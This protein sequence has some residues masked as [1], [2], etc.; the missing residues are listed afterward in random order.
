MT[1]NAENVS[2]WWR[3]HGDG[4]GEHDGY[5]TDG[6]YVLL[7]GDSN[8]RA[9]L[10]DAPFMVDRQAISGTDIFD[11]D[12]LITESTVP[13]KQLSAIINHRHVCFDPVNK[14]P[15]NAMY[16]AC[17]ECVNGITEMYPN[18]DMVIS[19]ILIRAPRKNCTF[20]QLNTETLS[21]NNKLCE[22]ESDSI[23]IDNFCQFM[24]N[25]VTQEL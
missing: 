5:G 13:A 8:C 22:L 12:N 4:G 3:H 16:L 14:N 24:N 20:Y 23:F 2:I 1:S 10:L 15:V 19:S 21:L 7:I 25:D 11:I 9:L 17:V 6:K 18:A